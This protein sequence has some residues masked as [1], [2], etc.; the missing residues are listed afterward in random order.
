MTADLPM[1]RPDDV[2]ASGIHAGFP[3]V[4]LSNG[5]GY[6]CGYIRVGPTH[7]WHG[8]DYH[9]DAIQDVE[10]HG[11]LTF[12]RRG[13]HFD[14][15]GSNVGWWLGFDCAHADDGQDFALMPSSLA[16]YAAK[17]EELRLAA[18]FQPKAKVWTTEDVEAECKR[19]C[20]Q[21]AKAVRAKDRQ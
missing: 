21:A 16:K 15:G 13:L 18:G 14:A 12:S 5:M 7:P 6:R 20:E 19:L 9:S 4:V 8:L 1:N 11:G 3:W 2:L 10:V 17:A